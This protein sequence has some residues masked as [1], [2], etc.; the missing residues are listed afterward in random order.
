[1]VEQP[2]VVVIARDRRWSAQVAAVVINSTRGR[3]RAATL[4]VWVLGFAFV[5]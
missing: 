2:R 5:V 4:A 3:K 1:M